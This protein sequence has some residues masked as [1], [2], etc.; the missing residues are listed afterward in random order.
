MKSQSVSVK[1]WVAQHM[2]LRQDRVSIACMAFGERATDE[3]VMRRGQ[4]S[5][6]IVPIF[7]H[8]W[9][10]IVVCDTFVE[11]SYMR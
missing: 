7:S 9:D 5:Q 2:G 11:L 8:M 6:V 1:I 3:D 4:G 10:A